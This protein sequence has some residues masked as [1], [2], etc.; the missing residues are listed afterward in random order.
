MIGRGL[1]KHHSKTLCHVVDFAQSWKTGVNSVPTLEG[2][3]DGLEKLSIYGSSSEEADTKA[4]EIK[5][6]S[7]RI[8]ELLTSKFIDGIDV[9]QEA[10]IISPLSM[11]SSILTT[12][13]N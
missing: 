3:I 11:E 10:G 1:R 9:H 5:E 2:T 13:V 4:K 6:S 8:E 7:R 12:W